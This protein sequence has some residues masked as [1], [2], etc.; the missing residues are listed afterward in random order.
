MFN[1]NNAQGQARPISTSF[2]SGAYLYQ[3]AEG[4]NGSFM[5]GFYKYAGELG[6][7]VVPPGGYYV[8]G[9]RTP[10]LSTLWPNAAITLYQG[11]QEV[12][13]I[14]VTR[15]DGPDGDKS[16]NP[17]GLANRGYPAGMTPPDYTY[18]TT[19]PVVKSG[20]FTIIARADGSAENI[21][22]KLDGGVDLNGTRPTNNTDPAFRDHPPGIFSDVWMGYEQPTFAWRQYQEKFA[23]VD[24]TRCKTGTSAGAETFV[25]TIG[26][27]VTVNAG[28]VGA[29]SN[30]STEGSTLPAFIYHNPDALVEGP[31]DKPGVG[32]KQFDESGADIVI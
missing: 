25:K 15:K 13:R 27:A 2:W 12:D 17:Y 24:T 1:D 19:V 23:A 21:V 8:F 14:T 22:L 3:Y 16:F 9:W 28:P 6:S 30:Y 4:P 29:N 26:G 18:R 7:V 20:N 10:E 11:G 5:G 31:A 32:K